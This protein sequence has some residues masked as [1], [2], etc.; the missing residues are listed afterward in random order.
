MI[1]KICIVGSS[2]LHTG[3]GK[4]TIALC[5]LLSRV[6]SVCFIPTDN[7]TDNYLYI[8]TGRKIPVCKNSDDV[9]ITFYCGVIW[10]YINDVTLNKMPQNG[11]HFAL[12]AFDSPTGATSPPAYIA[13]HP[14]QEDT[15]HKVHAA[16]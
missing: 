4:H 6:A 9:E 14:P 1:K 16:A 10:N 3:I 8:P 13:L 15:A 5:E 11:L 7:Y 12:I 2:N